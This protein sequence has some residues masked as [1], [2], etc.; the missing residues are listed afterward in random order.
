MASVPRRDPTP[1]T[2]PAR[3]G[4]RGALKAN[5][6]KNK[7]E[8]EKLLKD[9]RER[10]KQAEDAWAK[11]RKAAL[12]DMKFRAGDQ[13]PAEVKEARIK[14]GR[15]CLTV[16]KINQYIRQVVNDGRQNRPGV[17]V[18]PI[19]DASDPQVAA[20]F[21]GLIRDICSR[22]NADDAFDT[23][24]DC[25]ASSGF[26][27]FRVLTE[28][29]NDSHF[30]QNI[31]VRRVRNPLA[32]LTDPLAQMADGS[33]MEY[34][35]VVDD[36]RKDEFVRKFPKAE[37][38]NWET[39]H[40]EYGDG[41]LTDLTVRVCE[42]W[43]KV[44]ER[45][46][47]YLLEDGTTST[48]EDYEAAE[49]AGVGVP[50]VIDEREAQV[51]SVKWCRMSGA[52]VLEE[53]DWAGRYIPII[54]VYGTEMDIDGEVVYAGLIRP[55]RDAQMLY[56]YSRSAFAER[57]ALTPKS[58]WVAAV[59]QV[60]DNPEW[61]TANSENHAV[62][63]YN[64]V[65]VAGVMVPP[66][67]RI[68][69][70]DIPAGFAQDMAMSE[71]DIQAAIGMYSASL[72][73]PSNEKSGRAIMARQREGDTATF[74]FQDNL[75]RAVKH[76][77]R[78]LVDLIPK[79][80]DTKRIVRI[81]GD[82]DEAELVQVNP[83][84]PAATAKVTTPGGVLKVFNLN[85]GRYDVD[86]S[87]GPSYTTKRQESSEA[88]L[89]MAKQNPNIWVTHGDL[90]VK[91]QDWPQ[92]QEFA[93][94]TKALMPPDMRAAIDQAKAERDGPSPELRTL[95]DKASGAIEM[96]DQQ[97]A[98]LTDLAKRAGEEIE[99]LKKQL[100]DADLS[101]DLKAAEV[102]VKAY[103]AETDRL[104][105]LAPAMTPEVVQRIVLQTVAQLATP[106]DVGGGGD[107]DAR[108]E[109]TGEDAMMMPPE[110]MPP[111][112]GEAMM[113]PD[114]MGEEGAP[115]MMVPPAGSPDE[116]APEPMPPV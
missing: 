58:P 113:A 85:V 109:M 66:P 15:P 98:Q 16:D 53:R 12:E 107:V 33:D 40:R 44:P 70:S 34:A 32:V 102:D 93:D 104:K 61:E 78:V 79:I 96:R 64:P 91:S 37:K 55:A 48:R 13:W 19:D 59:G 28:Y 106:L 60:E 54:P 86:I 27:Y 17:K 73:Q 10:Y 76:L 114:M 21:S 84:L 110:P 23:A 97:I 92:A 111:L 90:I 31:C 116:P 67:Q 24:Q 63:R 14:Q 80:L 99:S 112:E 74:H 94:R 50:E 18:R 38:V 75:N 101:H 57:V 71:H 105:T 1:P 49:A 36:M 2:V 62:L 52:E 29:A 42:Y 95:M 41:W 72:G 81:V 77:G 43:Y 100:E 47:I 51:M 69:A 89:E 8:N 68:S 108:E 9:A 20:V 56:N 88:M 65:D 6:S 11:N 45:K 25:A 83:D 4:G 82:D 5:F 46:T 87:A 22:S 115:P 30:E 103:Q 39:D 26:G 7:N 3:G 35:F